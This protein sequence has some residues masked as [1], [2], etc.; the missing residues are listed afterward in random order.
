MEKTKQAWVLSK[1]PISLLILVVFQYVV[2]RKQR[3]LVHEREKSQLGGLEWCILP[4]L[5]KMPYS[6]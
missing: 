4:C 1:M 6:S 5:L 3:E 2:R